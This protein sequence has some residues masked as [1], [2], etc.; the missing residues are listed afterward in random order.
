MGSH[1]DMVLSSERLGQL[2]SALRAT[3]K[4]PAD[5]VDEVQWLAAQ[6]NALEAER[7]ELDA[8]SGIL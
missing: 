6:C 3:V 1:Q 2:R 4:R 5:L 8:S 7:N